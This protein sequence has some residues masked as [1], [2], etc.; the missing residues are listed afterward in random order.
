MF[1]LRLTPHF[2]FPTRAYHGTPVAVA[3]MDVMD[4]PPDR[5]VA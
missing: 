3:M 1:A 5:A 2:I 4:A